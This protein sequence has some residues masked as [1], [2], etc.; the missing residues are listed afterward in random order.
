ML[1]TVSGLPLHPLLVHL[2]VVAVPVAAVLA[3]IFA[4]SRRLRAR[5]ATVTISLS[6]VA[7][8]STVLA[9]SAGEAMLPGL[10]YNEANPGP[11]ADH[12]ELANYLL[13]AVLVMFIGTAI[14]YISENARLMSMM[15]NQSLKSLAIK[16]RPIGLILAIIGAV[17]SLVFVIMTGHEGAVLTWKVLS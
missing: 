11:V 13:V 7:V 2:A 15:K 6:I 10:G 4:A 3:L 5:V 16:A 14:G 17:A 9:R 1:N 8:L 12:A